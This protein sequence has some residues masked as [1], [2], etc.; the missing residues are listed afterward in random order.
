M[1]LS[2]ALAW[3]KTNEVHL[4]ILTPT[5][6]SKPLYSRHGFSDAHDLMQLGITCIRRGSGLTRQDQTSVG[7]MMCPLMGREYAYAIN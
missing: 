4:V 6:R 3:A 5:E 7:P 1:L 2:T